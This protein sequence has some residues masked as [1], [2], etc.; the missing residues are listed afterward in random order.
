MKDT[1]IYHNQILGQF[2]KSWDDDQDEAAKLLI[3]A[4]SDRQSLFQA[5]I[6]SRRWRLTNL[7]LTSSDIDINRRSKANGRSLLHN[8]VLSCRKEGFQDGVGRVTLACRLLARGALVTLQDYNGENN[9]HLAARQGSLHPLQKWFYDLDVESGQLKVAFS[10]RSR[11]GKTPA[12]L[13][14]SFD[15]EL[16]KLIDRAFNTGK[17]LGVS[18]PERLDPI[19]SIYEVS[20][21]VLKE[22]FRE[23]MRSVGLILPS[24]NCV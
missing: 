22:R 4:S 15:Y 1:Y 11:K 18:E 8:L 17:E 21:S 20:D 3:A 5:A 12:T 7:A 9:Y 14:S 6:A 16:K 24:G 13:A 19:G 10:T 2:M 23:R